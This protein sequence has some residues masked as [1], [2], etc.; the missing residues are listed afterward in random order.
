MSEQTEVQSLA[1][2]VNAAKVHEVS[3]LIA[4]FVVVPKDHTVRDLR[5]LQAEPSRIVGSVS[6]DSVES[7]ISYSRKFSDSRST[8]FASEVS[9]EI[10]VLMDYH[11][12][13]APS[14]NTHKAAYKAKPSREWNAWM[15]IHGKAMDQIA[16]AEFLEEH[17]ADVVQPAGAELLELATK[18]QLIRKAVFGSAARLQSGE[19]QFKYSDEN[20]KGSI[21]VPEVITLGIPVFHAGKPY[22]ITARLRYRLADEGKLF[23]IVKLNDPER[24]VEHAFKSITEQV[25]RE[26]AD[27]PY[28]DA[29]P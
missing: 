8:I 26:L 17:T 25:K 10:M 2:L 29:V 12:P 9:R 22:S 6:A 3:G 5:E 14:R 16:F 20:Q 15:A 13:N 7:L 11:T 18:F 27:L 19:F 4:P 24:T 23:F 21:E 28:Y 1:G